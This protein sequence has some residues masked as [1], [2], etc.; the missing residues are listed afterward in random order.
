MKIIN[1]TINMNRFFTTLSLFL[2]FAPWVS[3]RGQN[4]MLCQEVL[5]SAGKTAKQGNRY[6]AYTVGEPFISTLSGTGF[7]ATQGFHQPELCKLVSTNNIDLERWR[8]EVFPNPSVDQINVR[9]EQA[10][11]ARLYLRVYDA[12]G[13]L[14]VPDKMVEQ[15]NGSSLDCSAWE[16][17]VFIL[18]FYTL[19]G[20]GIATH[21]LI[22]L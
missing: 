11:D 19:P 16:A 6:F 7:K 1:V 18:Q 14:V 2:F 15:P 20:S 21:K 10:G 5:A 22:K 13:R 8:L 4:V 9:F 3:L 12:L 17:G